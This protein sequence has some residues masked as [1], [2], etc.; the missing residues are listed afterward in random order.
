MAKYTRHGR[1]TGVPMH[2]GYIEPKR[3]RRQ[4]VSPR[5]SREARLRLRILAYAEIHSVA[6]TCRHFGIAR[7]TYYRW[8]QRYI[9]QRPATLDNRSSRPHAPRRPT[10]TTQEALAVRDLRAQFPRMGKEKLAVLLHA[11]DLHLSVS[12]VGRILTYLR[13]T[14]QLIEPVA[15]TPWKTYTRHP[16]PYAIRKPKDYP[17]D[18]LQF[19]TMD[20][21]PRAGMIRKHFTAVDLVSRVS[22][23]ATRTAAS[24]TTACDFL[25]Q[26]Q[27][28][29]S[30]PIK[31]MQVDGGS[32]FMAEFEATC[33]ER[34]IRLFVLPPRFQR[35][36]T[37][38][39]LV[40]GCVERTNR[41]YRQEFYECYDGPLDL[42]TLQ[43]ALADFQHT[44][45]HVRPHQALG[46]RTPAA[47]LGAFAN[48]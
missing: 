4:P 27:R 44:Y 1:P 17:V 14:S 48:V 10:W 31:A 45:N 36:P 35:A 2:Y 16:R 46:Y 47:A 41:T 39:P 26:L 42:P 24:A 21:R 3:T 29:F 25:D 40:A 6:A 34:G 7:S 19:D 32:E 30:V 28:Q 23:A 11:Q 12:T 33:R 15:R 9:P 20:L 5:E 13:A 18:L 43:I 38:K 22:S 8:K 37:A